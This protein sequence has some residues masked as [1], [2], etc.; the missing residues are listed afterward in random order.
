MPKNILHVVEC[1][2]VNCVNKMSIS[3]CRCGGQYDSPCAGRDVIDPCLVEITN[4]RVVQ[5]LRT[6]EGLEACIRLPC[7]S[8]C[9]LCVDCW[10]LF[11]G[12]D[13]ARQDVTSR[14][15]NTKQ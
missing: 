3:G 14:P 2:M 13:Y 5:V 1:D 4:W 6:I 12:P 7:L 10:M 8:I 9:S 11:N 15:L